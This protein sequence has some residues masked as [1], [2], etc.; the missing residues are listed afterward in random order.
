[1]VKKFIEKIITILVV[2]GLIIS[3]TNILEFFIPSFRAFLFKIIA[4][5]GNASYDT[6]FRTHG[7][8]SGGG[9]SLSLGILVLSL[10]SYFKFTIS[11]RILYSKNLLLQCTYI[12]LFIEIS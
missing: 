11:V 4:V 3:T 1:M 7:F 12:Y 6:S 2:S 5:A 9:A 8:A 10:I